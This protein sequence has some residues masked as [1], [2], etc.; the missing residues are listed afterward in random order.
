MHRG[1]RTLGMP[2][3]IS[4]PGTGTHTGTISRQPLLAAFLILSALPVVG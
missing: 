1:N 2:M 3:S 4:V